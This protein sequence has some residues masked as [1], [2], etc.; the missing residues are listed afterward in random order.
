MPQ[1]DF[2]TSEKSRLFTDVSFIKEPEMSKI[3]GSILSMAKKL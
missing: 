3:Q 1:H 2:W